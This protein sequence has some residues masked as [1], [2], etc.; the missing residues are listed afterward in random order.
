[1]AR[2]WNGLMGLVLTAAAVQAWA[3]QP[4]V[5]HF[6][7]SATVVA[8]CA[9]TTPMSAPRL[10][11]LS[12]ASY[13]SVDCGQS[14]ALAQSSSGSLAAAFTA[15]SRIQIDESDSLVRVTVEF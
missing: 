10:A 15:P 3:A 1:V 6:T 14:G 13:V 7:V 2:V 9:A 11:G 4:P 8:R 5:A 12:A